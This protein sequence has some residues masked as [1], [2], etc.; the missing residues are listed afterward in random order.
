MN[1]QL[2]TLLLSALL[3]VVIVPSAQAGFADKILPT[4]DAAKG[5]TASA[6]ARSV[7]VTFGPQAAKLYRKLAGQNAQV[8]CGDPSV[9]S[10]GSFGTTAT[11]DDSH[12]TSGGLWWTGRKLP[13]RRGSVS[14]PRAGSADLCFIATD[15]RRSD[16]GCMPFVSDDCVRLLVAVND[17]GRASL[18]AFARAIELDLAFTTPLE[19]L[20]E[21]LGANAIIAMPAPDAALAPGQVG[22]FDDGTNRTAATLRANGQRLFVSRS[23]GVFSTNVPALSVPFPIRGLL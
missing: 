10:D 3:L 5:V 8:G 12:T 11:P 19:E 23:A 14:F 17:T 18:D 2:R 6:S 1:R 16:D 20:R 21:E 7:R 9:R 13:R 15:E 4:V 22:V